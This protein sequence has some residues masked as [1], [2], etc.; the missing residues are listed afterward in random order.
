M[1]AQQGDA[2]LTCEQVDDVRVYLE[3]LAG[4]PLQH[5]GTQ[6]LPTAL[7]QAFQRDPAVVAD[8]LSRVRV[9]GRRLEQTSGL[10]AAALRSEEVWRAHR[11]EGIFREPDGLVWNIQRDALSVWAWSDEERLALTE[12]DIEAWLTYASL[13][14]EAQQAGV[15]RVS[16][17]DRVSAYRAVVDRFEAGD[18][19]EK[20]AMGAL[21]PFWPQ[22]RDRWQAAS[23]EVQQGWARSAPLPPPM[24]ATSL[25]YLQAIV[26]G[27]V[28]T[29][30]AVVHI[31]LG[32]LALNRE[33]WRFDQP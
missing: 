17:A 30:V 12:S 8:W 33:A 6:R 22:I 29:H 31:A 26:D 5:N 13:C 25:G 14:R 11:G 18:R 10:D 9:E 28:V 1:L 20:L 32:P 27:D 16:V 4:R 3:L 15:L 21:G 7:V 24:S 2:A 19:E 23:Y